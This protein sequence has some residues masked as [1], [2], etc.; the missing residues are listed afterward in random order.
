MET[1]Q[2]ET[3]KRVLPSWLTAQVAAKNVA[4]V[5][6]PKRRRMA[7]VPVAAA[8]CDNPGQ[9]T[10]AKRDRKQEKPC[11]QPALAG[12]DNPQPSP[13]CSVSPHTS[14]GSSSEEEDSGKQV[15]A[16]GLSPSQRPGSSNSPS[17]RSPEEEEEEE[18]VL[19]YVRE[20]FFS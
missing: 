11:E 3:K 19:K 20:I 10:H 12:T 4:P 5:K 18:D 6:A 8:R 7:A 17:S 14:S 15:P 1:L 2:P 13:P 16:P 9:R